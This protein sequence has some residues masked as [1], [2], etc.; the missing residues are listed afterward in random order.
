MEN[1]KD[2]ILKLLRLDTLIDNLSGF[3]EARLELFKLEIRED[4]AKVLSRTLI[5]L[6]IAMLG[7]LFLVFF[8]V[9]LAHFLNRSF[10][11]AFAGY[12]IVSGIY[13]FAFLVLIVFRKGIDRSFE[14][15][16]MEMIKRKNK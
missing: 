16:F 14:K 5:Y 3:V 15:H 13:G 7:L 12:W 6:G 9:G 2:K 11:D 8:S 10:A 1:L 4:I